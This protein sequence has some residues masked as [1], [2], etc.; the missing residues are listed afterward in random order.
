MQFFVTQ[1]VIGRKRL[2]DSLC[3]SWLCANTVSGWNTFQQLT[4]P[5]TNTTAIIPV[6]GPH[7]FCNPL[8]LLCNSLL[9]KHS[10]KRK[11]CSASSIYNNNSTALC[12]ERERERER[13]RVAAAAAKAKKKN[14][15][16]ETSVCLTYENRGLCLLAC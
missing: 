16:P 7:R 11:Y 15:N 12:I 10:G 5:H 1:S 2:R 6:R 14:K 8:R 4:P 3:D 9:K 13:E